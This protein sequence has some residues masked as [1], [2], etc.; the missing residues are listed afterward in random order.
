MQQLNDQAL[1]DYANR[2]DAHYAEVSDLA[3]KKYGM[4]K[5]QPNA[6]L[7]FAY[8]GEPFLLQL[9]Y[10]DNPDQDFRT[11]YAYAIKGK[12]DATANYIREILGL[13]LNQLP[14]EILENIQMNMNPYD[15]ARLG[16]TNKHFKEWMK[17]ASERIKFITS[18]E[19]AA[20]VSIRTL[21]RDNMYRVRMVGSKAKSGKSSLTFFDPDRIL[22]ESGTKPLWTQYEYNL[23][24]T[25]EPIKTGDIYTNE[26][27]DSFYIEDI[28]TNYVM[29]IDEEKYPPWYWEVALLAL[30]IYTR[31]VFKYKFS[32][33]ILQKVRNNMEYKKI[34]AH[35]RISYMSQVKLYGKT[36]TFVFNSMPGKNTKKVLLENLDKFTW[37]FAYYPDAGNIVNMNYDDVVRDIRF[38]A[39]T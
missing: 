22:E 26:S 29:T 37:S 39:L 11:A 6:I 21:G 20:N 23:E 17:D 12:H 2:S 25:D 27:R 32:P 1:I 38:R 33:S 34:S 10:E 36:Y 18:Y 16:M 7:H 19:N 14:A 30:K 13:T 3:Q 8:R 35:T 4:Y 31:Y 28:H 5:N 24:S 9:A 15:Q